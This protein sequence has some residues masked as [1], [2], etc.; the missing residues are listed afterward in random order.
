M[1][2]FL[3]LVAIFGGLWF[4]GLKYE[5][6]Y[7]TSL[8]SF[9]QG[10]PSGVIDD[11][12][13]LDSLFEALTSNAAQYESLMDELASIKTATGA[14]RRLKG[15]RPRES[16]FRTQIASTMGYNSLHEAI[17]YS[18]QLLAAGGVDDSIPDLTA[19][20][21][22]Y[23]LGLLSGLVVFAI[24]V[25][26]ITDG[27]TTFMESLNE[28]KT[29]VVTAGHTLVLGTNEATPRLVAQIAHMR[30]AQTQ[31]NSSFRQKYLGI[32]IHPPS[33]SVAVAPVVVRAGTDTSR[34]VSFCAG[35]LLNISAKFW[36][37]SESVVGVPARADPSL[38]R[39]STVAADF[40]S[41]GLTEC[42][43]LKVHSKIRPNEQDR[44]SAFGTP[45][46]SSS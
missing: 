8:K 17:W 1:A 13:A 5:V 35:V 22:I 27:V 9:E 30:R 4:L 10:T 32:G 24:L 38:G 14:S 37:I 46:R 28:G 12:G 20:R 19:L 44:H 7:G 40:C 18:V 3:G 15:V 31:C 45:R 11:D 36:R 6:N 34:C 2:L 33:T 26:F 29:K 42:R 25:G 16:G 23:F 21:V 41:V 39:T 43:P